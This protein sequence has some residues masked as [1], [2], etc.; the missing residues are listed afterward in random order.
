MLRAGSYY[1]IHAWCEFLIAPVFDKGV[2]VAH[3]YLPQGTWI[4][5]WTNKTITQKVGGYINQNAAIKEPAVFRRSRED[6]YSAASRI[7]VETHQK[8]MKLHRTWSI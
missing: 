6:D 8:L 3:V 2:N 4:H 1:S 7:A 5:V